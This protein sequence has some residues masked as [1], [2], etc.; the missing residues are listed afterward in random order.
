MNIVFILG[1][2]WCELN[3]LNPNQA[4][5]AGGPW[6]HA[7]FPPHLTGML[8]E[9]PRQL[10]YLCQSPM[11]P[12]QSNSVWLKC[13]RQMILQDHLFTQIDCRRTHW[14]WCVKSQNIYA[15]NYPM[16]RCSLLVPDSE[17]WWLMVGMDCGANRRG[18]LSNRARH[19]VTLYDEQRLMVRDPFG[20]CSFALPTKIKDDTRTNRHILFL[21]GWPTQRGSSSEGLKEDVL[22][23]TFNGN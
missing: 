3:V 11:T 16:N 4:K 8:V 19:K 15:N 7:R 14:R 5:S 17:P 2:S 18:S 10:L 6:G 23:C 20:L 13:V 9:G 21:L 12:I 22:G 1:M